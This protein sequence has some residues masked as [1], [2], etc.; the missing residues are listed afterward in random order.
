MRFFNIMN[1]NNF[2]IKS[3]GNVITSRGE[4]KMSTLNSE[5]ASDRVPYNHSLE[6]LHCSSQHESNEPQ[7]TKQPSRRKV[8]L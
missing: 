7:F 2:A 6:C 1:I 3:S 5:K 4:M 8:V